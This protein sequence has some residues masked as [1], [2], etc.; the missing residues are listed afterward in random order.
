MAKKQTTKEIG[1]N[2]KALL[3]FLAVVFVLIGASYQIVSSYIYKY[4]LAADLASIVSIRE[5]VLNAAD[6]TRTNAPID[7]KTGDTYFPQARLYLPA[8]PDV[9]QLTYFYD[10]NGLSGQE[11]S[12]SRRSVFNQN[13]VKLYSAMNITQLFNAIP[14]VQSCQRGI[15]L[16]YKM[17]KDELSE[18]KQTI[19]LNNGKTLYAYQE[20]ACPELNYTT[21][22]LKNLRAY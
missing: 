21:S 16:Q 12:I 8:N 20:T 5:L 3:I 6:G 7:A 17:T 19:V 10:A 14:K 15:R 2:R 1:V 4:N 18:L 22:L 13:A 9:T 11:L